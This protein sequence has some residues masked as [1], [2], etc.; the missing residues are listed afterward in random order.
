MTRIA[1]RD[2]RAN[3]G[4]LGLCAVFIAANISFQLIYLGDVGEGEF[5]DP[6][7]NTFGIPEPSLD[8]VDCSNPLVCILDSAKAIGQV[9]VAGFLFFVNAII[10]VV[11]VTAIFFKMMT[12]QAFPDA[13]SW[14]KVIPLSFV[15]VAVGW[16]ILVL[17]FSRSG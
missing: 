3:A 5:F 12:F 4:L 1:K 6:V 2:D 16:S 13:P 17:V 8:D 9:A 14:L 15:S 7:V 11:N 10:M